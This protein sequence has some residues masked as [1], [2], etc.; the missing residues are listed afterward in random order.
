M[1]PANKHVIVYMISVE[2]RLKHTKLAEQRVTTD[3]SCLE[4]VFTGWKIAR[5]SEY[6]L[7]INFLRR[8][9]AAFMIIRI[10]ID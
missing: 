7:A 9:S 5:V 1:T 8:K 4:I 6:R 2:L 10:P 3:V